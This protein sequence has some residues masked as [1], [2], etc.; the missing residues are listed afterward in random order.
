[1][2][3][4]IMKKT[5]WKREKKK[6]RKENKSH[7]EQ[8]RDDWLIRLGSDKITT[9]I[10]KKQIQVQMRVATEISKKSYFCIVQAIFV[11]KGLWY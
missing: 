2:P 8:W 6:K 11:F 9:K 4:F 10:Q 5:K 7:N 1:M 3:T